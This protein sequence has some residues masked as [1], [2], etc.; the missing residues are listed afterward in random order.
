MEQIVNNQNVDYIR[1][2][3]AQKE[4][5]VHRETLMR[6]A[7]IGEVRTLIKPGRAVLYSLDDVRALAT[8]KA[9]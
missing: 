9:G 2:Q 1:A 3:R 6:M 5:G 4:F 8:G 7:L